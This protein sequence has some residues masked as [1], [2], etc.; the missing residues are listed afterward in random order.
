MDR[1]HRL[2]QFPTPTH[3]KVM[4]MLK[5]ISTSV[6]TLLLLM[7]AL[8]VYA[9]DAEMSG[10]DGVVVAEGFSAP[11]GVLVDDD[12]NVLVIDSGVGGDEEIEFF[13]TQAMSMITAT[14]GSSAQIV[15]VAP[16]GSQAVLANLPSLATGFDNLGGARMA[17]LDGVLYATVGQYSSDAEDVG[18]EGI[19]TVVAIGEGEHEVVASTWDFER[20]N[21]PDGTSLI[22]SHPY[23]LSAGPDGLLYVADSGANSVFSVDPTSG[24]VALVA[25]IDPIPGVFPSETRN[26]ELLADPVPTAVEWDA[27]GNLLVAVSIGCTL[28]SGQQRRQS[29]GGRRHGQ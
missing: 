14:L 12:G 6:L 5:H 21:N 18:L 8:P 9:Q 20:A 25:V 17:L 11:Q 7:V 24:E 4:H 27:D 2:L 22:D 1:L 16:D 13:S 3:S 15:S 26:G 29:G 23:G 19:A 10:A 28:Y